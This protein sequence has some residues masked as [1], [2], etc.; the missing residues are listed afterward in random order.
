MFCICI[1]TSSINRYKHHRSAKLPWQFSSQILANT[2]HGHGLGHR[3]IMGRLW[4]KSSTGSWRLCIYITWFPVVTYKYTRLLK[5]L[6]GQLKIK[7]SDHFACPA[8]WFDLKHSSYSPKIL[9]LKS[10][11]SMVL[12]QEMDIYCNL[13]FPRQMLKSVAILPNK[14]ISSQTARQCIAHSPKHSVTPLGAVWSRPCGTYRQVLTNTR[15][16]LPSLFIL[17]LAEVGF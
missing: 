16:T 9:H 15:A 6:P 4:F 3:A 8:L 2:Y 10:E 7:L 12:T 17:A 11:N 13:G 5:E 14:I 1:F